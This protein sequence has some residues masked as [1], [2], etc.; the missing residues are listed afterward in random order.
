LLLI[1]KT[2]SENRSK[3]P[4]QN[5]RAQLNWHPFPSIHQL[6]ALNEGELTMV[7]LRSE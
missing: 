7:K 1:L 2:K 6:K 4:V 3:L 5:Q